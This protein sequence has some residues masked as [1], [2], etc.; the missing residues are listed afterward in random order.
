M[1][2]AARARII[3]ATIEPWVDLHHTPR[4]R[5]GLER[6]PLERSL[7]QMPTKWT[8]ISQ[9]WGSLHNRH[10][11]CIVR[12]PDSLGLSGSC[13]RVLIRASGFRVHLDHTHQT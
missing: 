11:N 8:E 5:L 6:I 9:L 2:R 3:F 4:V 13:I 7:H 12:D 1:E 10:Y